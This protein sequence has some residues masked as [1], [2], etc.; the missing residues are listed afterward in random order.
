MEPLQFSGVQRA[1]PWIARIRPRL[2][3]L[4]RGEWP[5]G[6]V[7]A[8]RSCF[9]HELVIFTAGTTRAVVGD[10]E[11]HCQPGD[12]LIQPPGVVQ[13]SQAAA[14]VVER[15][16]FHF[17]WT[18][19]W[20]PLTQLPYC[21]LHQGVV[22]RRELRPAPEWLPL[23]MPWFVWG[24]APQLSRLVAELHRCARNADA[25][26]DLRRIEARC[27]EV[28]AVVLAGS[29]ADAEP[30][31]GLALVTAVKSALDAIWQGRSISTRWRPRMASR[32]TI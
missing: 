16:T 1:H 5:A 9:D 23:P 19:E 25:A 28:L 13:W 10:L 4:W 2:N 12:A 17:D 18:S 24:A 14:G 31:P 27:C 7:Q 11:Y 29:A 3:V 26:S 15:C 21:F 6:H 32:A 8:S 22:A 20:P 30:S